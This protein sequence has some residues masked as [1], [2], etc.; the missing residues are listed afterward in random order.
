LD[1]AQGVGPYVFDPQIPSHLHGI[2]ERLCE[3]S[4]QNA[5][6]ELLQSVRSKDV[7]RMSAP[8]MAVRDLSLRLR[9]CLL[10]YA[11]ED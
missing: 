2:H 6:V 9:E 11:D 10:D 1:N 4:N 8:P 7:D 5:A 3:L